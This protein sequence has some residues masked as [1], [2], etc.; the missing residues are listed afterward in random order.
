MAFADGGEFVFLDLT[1]PAFDLTDRGVGGRP[2]PGPVDAYLYT[3]RGVYRPGES[4]HAVALLRSDKAAALGDLPVVLRLIRP[5]GVEARRFK[6]RAGQ[7]DGGHKVTIPLASSARTGRWTLSA[8]VDPKGK[9]IGTV[10]FQV[11]D[12]VPERLEV[13]L[14][15][16]APAMIAGIANAIIVNGRFLYGAPAADLRVESEL[17][18]QMNMQPYKAYKGYKFGLVQE[19]FRARRM[20]LKPLRTAANGL[21]EI[22]LLLKALPQTSRPLEALVRVSVIEPGGRATVRLVKLPVQPKAL[23]IGIR[24]TFE[25]SVQTGNSAGFEIVTL[26]KTGAARVTAGLSYELVRE[27][28][29]YHWYYRNGRWGYRVTMEE[30]ETRKGKL[31]VTKSPAKLDF[32]LTWGA[33]RLEVRDKQTGAATSVRFRVG[34][35]AS[36]SAG[37]VPDKLKVTLDRKSYKAGETAKV[38]VKPPFD[39]RV[40]I[41]IA[42]DR[43]HEVRS[44]EVPAAGRMIEIPV[45]ADWGPS[46]YIL[47][48]AFRPGEQAGARGPARAIGLAHLKMDMSDSTLAVTIGGP[49]LSKPRR[50]IEVP[51]KVTGMPRGGR[52]YVTLAAVDEGILQLTNYKSPKPEQ[53]Y[54][55][56]RRLAVELRDDY[57]RLIDPGKAAFGQVRQGGDAASRRHLS[58]LDASSVKTVAL[59]SGI[60]RVDGEGNAK[61]TLEIPDFN[62]RLRLMAVAWNGEKVGSGESALTVRDDVVSIVTLPRFLAPRDVAQMTVSLHNVGGAAGPYKL[63]VTGSLAKPVGGAGPAHLPVGQGP[64]PGRG[65]ETERG[66]GRGRPG[67]NGG[68]WA[69]RLPHRARLEHRRA[70]GPDGCHSA[71]RPTRRAGRGGRL[72]PDRACQFREGHRRG[73]GRILHR[74]RFQSGRAYKA[75]RPLSVWLCRADHEPRLAAALCG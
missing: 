73:R 11:E 64:T 15:P 17:V 33:Y 60:V 2:A 40:Q 66:P 44:V 50:T 45:K 56:K 13:K 51:I 42:G 6:L 3:E 9:P 7:L 65:D 5:D 4:V 54:F 37:D 35:W 52:A 23:T 39:G 32:K 10:L 62:G 48:A 61:I 27:E 34:W 49:K 30:G 70:A 26:D 31:S 14:K 72:Q 63:T 43:V 55:G 29:R 57:G 22:P 36:A 74:S 71:F 58:G 41:V 28:Y 24:K 12:F 8:Y 53:H 46:T 47:A 75:A 25:G 38:F 19:T 20:P 59:F 21:V 69:E 16:K 18:L 1:R 67:E 68:H